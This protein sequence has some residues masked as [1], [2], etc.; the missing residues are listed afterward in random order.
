MNITIIKRK[1][2]TIAY[3]VGNNYLSQAINL[4]QVVS[5]LTH[6]LGS[7]WPSFYFIEENRIIQET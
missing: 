2:Y 3:V 1:D 7:G 4:I 6:I 5:Y